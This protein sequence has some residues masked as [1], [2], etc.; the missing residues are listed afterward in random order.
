MGAYTILRFAQV[1]SGTH[2]ASLSIIASIID[3]PSQSE[4]A[5]PCADEDCGIGSRR[6]IFVSLRPLSWIFDCSNVYLFL[7]LAGSTDFQ[8]L[9][10]NYPYMFLKSL[11]IVHSL[12]TKTSRTR[13]KWL[14]NV[15]VNELVMLYIILLHWVFKPATPLAIMTWH[16]AAPGKLGMLQFS[17]LFQDYKF[18]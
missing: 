5:R 8:L 18:L 6:F 17:T 9:L 10:N 14:I 2:W 16:S 15:E 1:P 4:N 11:S 7:Y 12:V 3:W 13:I